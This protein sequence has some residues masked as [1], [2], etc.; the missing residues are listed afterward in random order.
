MIMF[1][2]DLTLKRFLK[3]MNAMV[4][5]HV[6]YYVAEQMEFV[7]NW[8]FFHFCLLSVF[9]AE[10]LQV[11]QIV[12]N[13]EHIDKDN[14]PLRWSPGKPDCGPGYCGLYFLSGW[15]AGFWL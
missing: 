7:F 15:H 8:L 6:I 3:I 12:A 13:F 14:W 10:G 11:S 1:R 4:W 5:E 2:T 9:T